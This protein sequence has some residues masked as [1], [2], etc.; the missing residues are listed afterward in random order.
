MSRDDNN[1]RKDKE[2]DESHYFNQFVFLFELNARRRNKWRDLNLK[3]N[4]SDSGSC[5]CG[6]Q[7]EDVEKYC[8][9]GLKY[10]LKR[11]IW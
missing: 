10:I 4:I 6:Y 2:L 8:F 1:H 9:N 3:Q 5:Y 11:Q 7:T